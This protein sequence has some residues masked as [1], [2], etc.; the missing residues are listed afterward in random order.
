MSFPVKSPLADV[1]RHDISLSSHLFTVFTFAQE[2]REWGCKPDV[3]AME[4]AQQHGD[5]GDLIVKH[6]IEALSLNNTH[7]PMLI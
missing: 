1:A 7:T 6:S 2:A 3:C 5:A 4:V